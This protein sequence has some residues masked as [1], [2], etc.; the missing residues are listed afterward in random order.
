MCVSFLPPL[1]IIWGFGLQLQGGGLGASTLRGGEGIG[2]PAGLKIFTNTLAG[3][4]R[5]NKVNLCG[6]YCA[7]GGLKQQHSFHTWD[8]CF[9]CRFIGWIVFRL[10]VLS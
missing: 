7:V 5:T 9:L 6:G 3:L 10:C 4:Q 2:A 8:G 1:P